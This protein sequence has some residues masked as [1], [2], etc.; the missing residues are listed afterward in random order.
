MVFL[1]A[2]VDNHIVSPL[3]S[4]P[5]F[6]LRVNYLQLTPKSF[7]FFSFLWCG[8]CVLADPANHF[9]CL[10][11]LVIIYVLNTL[12]QFSLWEGFCGNQSSYSKLLQNYLFTT[13]YRGKY[14][15][16]RK[17]LFRLPMK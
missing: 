5:F 15:I 9:F 11:F 4:V 7:F 16:L 13:D 6:V 10:F 12:I 1:K 17:T 3:K 14:Q 2:L 8:V